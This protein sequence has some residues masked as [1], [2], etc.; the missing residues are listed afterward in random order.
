MNLRTL[1][2]LVSV[3]LASVAG[4]MGADA[5]DAMRDMPPAYRATVQNAM[6]SFMARDFKTALA[7][8]DQADRAHQVTALTV[9]IK[10]AVAIEEKRFDEG[11]E[12]V[13]KALQL[14]STF[15]PALFNLAEIPFMQGKYSEA[16]I[17]YERLLEEE[18]SGDLVKFRIYLTYLLEK[19]DERAQEELDRVPLLNDSP[20]YF[21]SHAAWA[22]AHGNEKE[23]RSY[24]KS[25]DAVF[26]PMKIAN[27][28]DVFYDLGWIKRVAPGE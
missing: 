2:F 5:A 19:N 18:G 7:L 12:L 16:R 15:F 10:A 4:A 22:F 13:L 14:D 17:A 20:I 3:L 8:V 24:I 25:A 21:Y 9:N 28:A 6:R 11:R 26:P 23:A 27:F 1:C